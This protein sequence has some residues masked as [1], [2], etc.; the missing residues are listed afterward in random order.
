[1]IFCCLFVCL[2]HNLWHMIIA[3]CIT[4]SLFLWLPYQC[5]TTHDEVIKWKHFPHYWTFVRGIHRSVVEFPSQRPVMQN[6]DVFFDLRLNK[7]LRKQS[8]CWWFEMPSSWLWCHCN[9]WYRVYQCHVELCTCIFI[10]GGTELMVT[11][12]SS[13][14]AND[15]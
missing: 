11:M 1:M 15:G 8:W 2:F 7:C 4:Q 6:F 5:F 13:G 12:A 9:L 3:F 10:S 14:A